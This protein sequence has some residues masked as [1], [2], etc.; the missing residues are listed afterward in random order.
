MDHP[1]CRCSVVPVDDSMQLEQVALQEDS[2]MSVM[3]PVEQREPFNPEIIA[4]CHRLA[5]TNNVHVEILID[6]DET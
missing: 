5:L 1:M 2:L 3:L 4:H 6:D